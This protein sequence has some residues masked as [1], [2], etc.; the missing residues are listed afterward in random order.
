MSG[1]NDLPRLRRVTEYLNLRRSA[2]ITQNLMLC[3][4]SYVC[5]SVYDLMLATKLP[6]LVKRGNA[7]AQDS[8]PFLL[9][10]GCTLRRELKCVICCAVLVKFGVRAVA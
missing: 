5:P 4:Y 7:A 9:I 6:H 1:T 3:V 8:C 10:A 2:E